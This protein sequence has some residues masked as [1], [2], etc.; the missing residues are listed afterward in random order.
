MTHCWRCHKCISHNPMQINFRA[1]CPFC[2]S[3]LHTCTNCRHH[4][5]NRHNE[6]MI[7]NTDP[8]RDREARNFCEDF[9]PRSNNQAETKPDIKNAINSL[10]KDPD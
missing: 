3:D 1:E 8:V 6:C 9:S 5:K 10:F 4:D 7:P 2:G